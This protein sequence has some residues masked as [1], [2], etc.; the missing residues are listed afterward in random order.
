MLEVTYD[1][2]VT[3][4]EGLCNA[5]DKLLE[6]AMSTPGILDE[7]GNPKVG[8]FL[9]GITT[10]RRQQDNVFPFTVT[11]AGLERHDG[12]AP[13]TY[14]VD[15]VDAA[16]ATRVVVAH[17]QAELGTTDLVVKA[18]ASGVPAADCWYHWNDLR[19]T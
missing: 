10:I 12:E 19:G 14:V 8:E 4:P 16:A 7:Y 6:T 13:Y 18:C 5:F 17:M 9:F 11:V 1:A 2:Q 15:A 3:D